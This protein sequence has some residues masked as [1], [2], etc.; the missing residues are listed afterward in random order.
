MCRRRGVLVETL[1]HLDE[2][3][4]FMLQR[5]RNE[6]AAAMADFFD[7]MLRVRE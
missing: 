4:D 3:R 6:V 1:V 5:T 7:R 2:V